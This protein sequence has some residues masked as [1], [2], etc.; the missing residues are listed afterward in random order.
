[1]HS[2][3]KA[4]ARRRPSRLRLHSPSARRA[5]SGLRRSPSVRTRSWLPR[6]PEQHQK[7]TTSRDASLL[8]CGG[9]A[10]RLVSR[11]EDRRPGSCLPDRMFETVSF[12]KTSFHR[13]SLTMSRRLAS[14]D[15]HA[16]PARFGPRSV[17]ISFQE[18]RRSST[19]DPRSS[20]AAGDLQAGLEAS[21]ATSRRSHLVG[22]ALKTM[23]QLA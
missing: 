19:R 12:A 8:R 20:S 7:T 21:E 3:S 1:M 17:P 2:R 14:V 16:Q 13:E 9:G 10:R 23:G 6:Q 15:V 18:S 4:A 11:L 5:P 22:L